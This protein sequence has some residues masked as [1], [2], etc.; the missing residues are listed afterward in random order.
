MFSRSTGNKNKGDEID[1]FKI[2]FLSGSMDATDLRRD[3]IP[4]KGWHMLL[5]LII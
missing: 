5:K 2:R 1:Y 3:A 4:Q